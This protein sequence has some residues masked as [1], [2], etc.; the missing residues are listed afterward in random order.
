VATNLSK[1][2][3]YVSPEV[4][5]KLE[6]ERVRRGLRSISAVA[7]E[8]LTRFEPEDEGEPAAPQADAK[9]IHSTPS[10][11]RSAPQVNHAAESEPPPSPAAPTTPASSTPS[12][13]F[14]A[15][16]KRP[17]L[18]GNW[19]PEERERMKHFVVL[20]D[21]EDIASTMPELNEEDEDTLNAFTTK[22]PT[23]VKPELLPG[24]G[25][26]DGTG[27]RSSLEEDRERPI[28]EGPDPFNWMRDAL[29]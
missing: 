27:W 1:I 16:P 13:A 15:A 6:T 23:P 14:G 5:A 19:T 12:S 22:P 25:E 28:G 8:I 21:R 7:A 4:L 24:H 2:Q 17:T 26:H 18:K 9:V 11:P 3:A 20:P 10:A 29:K